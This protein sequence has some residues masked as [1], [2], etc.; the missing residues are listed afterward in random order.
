MPKQSL[1]FV[2]LF[3]VVAIFTADRFAQAFSWYYQYWWFDD[4]MHFTGGFFVALFALYLY[5]HSDYITPRHNNSWFTILYALGAGAVVGVFWEFFE[6]AI[7]L[8]TGRTFN[9]ITVVNQRVGD[10]MSDLFFD[11]FGAVT[12]SLIFLRLW[13]KK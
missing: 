5:F 11:M 9:G 12:A 3:L 13:Q 10:T 6:F 1:I 4:L 8:Y 7:D 2:T